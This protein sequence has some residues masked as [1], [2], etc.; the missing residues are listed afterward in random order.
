MV[1]ETGS[2]T[3]AARA[4]NISQPAL[5][6]SIQQL[7]SELGVTL[8][9]RISKGVVLTRYG[10][11]FHHHAKM[12]ENEYRHAVSRIQELRDGLSGAI[13][14][15]AGPMWLVAILPPIVAR[16]QR[17]NPGVYI[18]LV[19]GVID[20]LLPNLLSGEL[21]LICVSLDFP[22]T[23]EIEKKPMFDVQ[24]VLIADPSHPLAKEPEVTPEAIHAFSWMVLKSDYVGNERIASFFASYGLPPPQVVFETTSIHSLL[25]GLRNGN[26]IAHIPTQ[27]LPLANTIGLEQI[28]LN[29]TIWETSAGYAYRHSAKTSVAVSNFMEMLQ[30]EVKGNKRLERQS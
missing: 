10:G 20:T 11:V 9:E 22:N 30:H 5:T 25:Q 6:K 29:K 12:M 17:E 13:R 4:L 14:I 28:R 1:A 3:E 15:G 19:G 23:P 7:E 16:F 21:D 18:S 24:H 2:I 27:L 8:F 26:Y